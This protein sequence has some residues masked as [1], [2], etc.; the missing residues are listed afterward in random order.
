M[1]LA[2]SRWELVVAPSDRFADRWDRAAPLTILLLGLCA[3]LLTALLLWS[4]A[5]T[6][7]H[8]RS[9]A[10]RM[11]G[12]LRR[13]ERTFRE[14]V[15]GTADF[16]L[17]IDAVGQLGFSNRALRES[18]A[19]E[20]SGV[21]AVNL[22]RILHPDERERFASI[23]EAV[24]RGEDPP[25]LVE[26]AF[27]TRQG[28]RIDVEGS[29]AMVRE[30]DTVEIRCIFRDVTERKRAEAALR[31]AND[32]LARLAAHDG[33]TDLPNRRSFEARFAEEIA[34]ARRLGTALS[35]VLLDV[36]NFKLY[37]DTYGHPAGDE[38]LRR[39]ARCVDEACRRAG[40][41]PARY[42]GEEFVLLLPGTDEAQAAA[43]AEH[44][45]AA[46]ETM[47][48]P[49]ER[50]GARVV[51]ASIGV[52]SLGTGERASAEELLQAADRA[53]YRAKDSGRNQVAKASS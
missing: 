52:A 26:T 12:A 10:L 5:R 4:L 43:I 50:N 13:S 36:D 41:L 2:G 37:N 30:E 53:L 27:V 16:I 51:T 14:V 32:Q 40:D 29:L 20:P 45:R 18:L 17:A 44:L 23:L 15:D 3:T 7:A 24:R 46:I 48:L 28:Q 33:L 42:G 31:M 19:L 6:E 25:A 35:L 38:C 8:S 1:D 39:V 22:S 47:R 49:H 9:L 34:R 11:T 21:T